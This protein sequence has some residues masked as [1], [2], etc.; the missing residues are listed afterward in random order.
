AQVRCPIRQLNA[1][2]INEW[3]GALHLSA[4]SVKN[5]RGAVSNLIDFAIGQKYLP[6][7]F[8]E[9]RFVR[10][11]KEEEGEVEIFT[12][13]EMQLLLRHARRSILPVLL[14][15]GFAGLRTSETLLVSWE[16]IHWEQGLITVPGRAKTGRRLAWMPGNL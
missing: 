10:T 7:G 14:L 5:Y 6:S 11:P 4:R 3:L 16:H 15:G 1:P 2:L 8:G 9:M 13:S 12:P